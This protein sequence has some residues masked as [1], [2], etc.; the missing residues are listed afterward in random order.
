MRPTTE[1]AEAIFADECGDYVADGSDVRLAKRKAEQVT[2]GGMLRLPSCGGVR[3]RFLG[4][5]KGRL[6][7]ASLLGSGQRKC[8]T[9]VAS[10]WT[11]A[12]N[13]L[14]DM[15]RRLCYPAEKGI[16][17]GRTWMSRVDNRGQ[18]W[19][20]SRVTG[21]M[22]KCCERKHRSETAAAQ[23]ASGRAESLNRLYAEGSEKTYQS[24]PEIRGLKE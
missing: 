19:A 7:E 11:V 10:E 21:T 12:L 1:N 17:A 9:M 3:L 8:L 20:V 2:F 14:V 13:D 5:R 18:G 24:Y 22:V 15:F 23:C 6:F 4:A 16:S